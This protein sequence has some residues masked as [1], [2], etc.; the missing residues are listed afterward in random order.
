MDKQD[1]QARLNSFKAMVE[2]HKR[3][4]IELGAVIEFMEKEIKEIAP[5]ILE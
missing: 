2:N 4:I 3:D 1:L 5:K